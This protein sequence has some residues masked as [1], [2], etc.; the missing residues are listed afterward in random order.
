[1][2]EARVTIDRGSYDA[3]IFD[4][5]GVV[6]QTAAV[7]AAA[8]KRLFDEYLRERAARE[9]AAS[10]APRQRPRR[11]AGG[12]PDRR[13][14]PPPPLRPR[15]RLRPLRGR[16][17]A[18]RRRARLPRSR[19]ASSCRWATPPTRRSAE[20]VCGLGNR[21]NDFFNAE[22]REHGVETFPSTIEVIG[23]L[24][25]AGIRTGLMSSS[26]NTAMV[27]DVTGTTDLFEVRVDGVVAAEVGLPGKPDPAMYLEAARRMGVDAARSV[28]VEDALS[29]VEAGHRGGFGLVI[30]VDRLGQAEALREAGADVVVDDLAEVDVGRASERDSRVAA[31]ARGS[32]RRTEHASAR[33]RGR[34]RDALVAGTR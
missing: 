22:V 27:L 5:D 16:Q 4:L 31:A 26:K 6:T 28:V 11:R 13:R 17:A 34:V 19:A 2:T 32:F 33:S 29:G 21:K 12:R 1:M 25:A 30:G 3:V 20:T 18:L 10:G 8:W 9:G 7:H 15:R 14:R 23:Q 24:H